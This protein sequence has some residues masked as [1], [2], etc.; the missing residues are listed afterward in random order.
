MSSHGQAGS[1]VLISYTGPDLMWAEWM[2]EQFQRAGYAT[3]TLETSGGPAADHVSQLRTVSDQHDHSVVV[4]SDRYIR[5]VFTSDRDAN[6]ILDWA[7]GRPD[8]LVPVLVR[9][10]N[11][12]V[13]FWRLSPVDLRG[14]SDEQTAARKLLTRLPGGRAADL[15]SESMT[16]F[17][18]HRPP[19]WS[20]D[21]PPRN[22]FFTGRDD[23]LRELRRRITTDVAAL[24]PHSLQGLAG[25][26]KTQLAVEYIYRFA[27]DYDLVWWIPA[28]KPAVARRALADLAI[29]LD[30]GGP[31]AEIGELI[32]AAKDA[33]RMGEPYDRWLVVFDNAGP[34]DTLTSLLPSGTGHVLITSRDQTWDRRADALD[35]DVYSRPESVEFLLRRAPALSGADASRLAAGL[36]DIPLALEHAAGWLASTG[37]GA[38]E[39]LD[40]LAKHTRDVLDTGRFSGYEVSVAATWTLSLQTLREASPAAAQL[41]EICA[42]IG[43]D[44]IPLRLFTSQ[45]AATTLP[46]PLGA[47]MASASEQAQVLQAIRSSSLAK[48]TGR[49]E[50]SEPALHQHRLVQ[51]VV[52]TLVDD[53]RQAAFRDLAHQLLA[54]AIPGDPEVPANWPAYD[55]LLPH[56]I[57]SGAT[58]DTAPGVRALV[59]S[60]AKLLNLRGEYET[61][62]E[63]SREAIR[64]WS[65][66]LDE[67]DRELIVMRRQQGQALRGLSR[68]AEVL[69][70]QRAGYELAVRR[71]GP[72][73]PDTIATIGGHAANN[74]RMMNIA[75]AHRLDEHAV[76]VM[77]GLRGP[78]DRETLRHEHNLAVDL[79]LAGDFG[80]ALEINERG[81]AIL[82]ELLGPD[83][84]STLYAVND[85][86]RDLRELG[87]VYESL[88]MQEQTFVH[89]REVF[90]PDSPD[91][92][93][94]MKNLAVSRRKA[95]RY[96]EA[97]ELA[98]DVL[99]R[100]QRK[101]GE[102]HPETLGATTNYASDL[103]CLGRYPEGRGYAES[104]LRGFRD[105]LGAEHPYAGIA[106]VNLAALVRLEDDPHGALTL[107]TEALQLLTAGFGAGHRYTLSC[108]VNLA[109]D[110]AQIGDVKAAR[111]LGVATLAGLSEA[112]GRD[113]PYTLSCAINLALDLRA[114]GERAAFRELYADTMQRYERT[115]GTGHPEAQTAAARERAVCDIEPPPV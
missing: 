54:G 57:S 13:G 69:E 104:A 14:L 100:H 45:T 29:R 74:R 7:S 106:A 87:R 111:D 24:V 67:I 114:V 12:P 72:D 110:R 90:G 17:P 65:G 42:F 102:H 44:P 86:A 25:V 99:E 60:I 1:R 96:A 79:R 76:A 35:V 94:A 9:R 77:T 109:S 97:A 18:G 92:L 101:F 8:A 82:T 36:D 105:L 40:Q 26:G 52:R 4:L 88:S 23:M 103:R 91:T 6:Q 71:L 34:P 37:S 41:L 15:V 70:V 112:S 73:H 53:A 83:A 47:E 63:I 50:H 5:T 108:A 93:R 3:A 19:V 33:L 78:D 43:P 89:Y 113:H 68:F 46:D 64:A 27:A 80:T 84:F 11:L 28:E 21:L 58:T 81:A 16:R 22:P 66:V 10:C 59:S 55:A 61:A 62:L 39:Y 49:S 56:V 85:T 51:S 95:G 115:L 30:R 75:E 38:D 48:L 31:R 98:R 2:A 107:N 32:R 20:P